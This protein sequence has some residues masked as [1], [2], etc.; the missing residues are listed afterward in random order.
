MWYADKAAFRAGSASG[1]SWNNHNVGDVSFACGHATEAFGQASMAGGSITRASGNY[2]FA[3]GFATTA[4]A[5]SSVSIGRYNDS[6]ASS[7]RD[8]WVLT[9]PLFIIGNGVNNVNPSNAMTVLKN[10]KTGINTSSPD[11]M[12]H[13]V[14]NGASGGSYQSNAA[15]IIEDNTDSFIQLSNPVNDENGILS[16]STVSNIR[17]GI[18]FRPDSSIALRAGGNDTRLLL[19]KTGDV[20]IDGILTQ[21]S[22]IRLKKNIQPLHNSLKKILTLSGYHYQWIEGSSDPQLQTGLLAQEIEKKM[23][24]LVKKGEGGIR[25]VNYIGLIPYLIEATKEQDKKIIDQEKKIEAL[26]KEINEIKKYLIEKQTR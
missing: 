4:R 6:I 24:E 1:D 25:S 7:S 20:T 3:T 14:R 5:S 11:A 26:E 16:G 21:N 15:V 13:I 19:S 2:S 22:D 18:V 8:S 17:S 9:D 10:A 23:P 12:L